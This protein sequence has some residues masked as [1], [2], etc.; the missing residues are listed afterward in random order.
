MRSRGSQNL[1]SRFF[2][3]KLF[4]VV[5]IVLLALVAI[6]YARAYYQNY[7]VQQEIA[8]LQEEVQLEKRKK[9][10]LLGILDYVQG[11]EYVEETARTELNL[12]KPGE[13]VIFVQGKNSS[14]LAVKESEIGNRG[15]HKFSNTIKW[16]Y[17]F[18][19]GELPTE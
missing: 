3:S 12:K 19:K 5:I 13:K 10:E 9:I 16:W 8:Q 11:D 4:F 18:T 17:Y 2:S 14:N 1:V 7:G 15:G 6:G